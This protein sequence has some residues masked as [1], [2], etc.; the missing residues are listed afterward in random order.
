[1]FIPDVLRVQTWIKHLALQLLYLLSSGLLREWFGPTPSID[2][3]GLK[4]T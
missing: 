2:G 4:K 3:L 1:M